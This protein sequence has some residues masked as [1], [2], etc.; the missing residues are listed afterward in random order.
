MAIAKIVTIS[1]PISNSKKMIHTALISQILNNHANAFTYIKQKKIP[2]N[3]HAIRAIL[4]LRE[5][6]IK[7]VVKR[8]N[9]LQVYL[10]L[11]SES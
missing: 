1:N 2:K 7:S 11:I 5:G 3:I 9:K 6:S 8:L 10:H 4:V